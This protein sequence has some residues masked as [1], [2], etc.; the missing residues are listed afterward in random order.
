M[1]QPAMRRAIRG[2][3]RSNEQPVKAGRRRYDP[4]PA[5]TEKPLPEGPMA[6]DLRKVGRYEEVR[7]DVEQEEELAYWSKT[8]GVTRDELRGAVAKVGPTV[9]E[10]RDHLLFRD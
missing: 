3:R 4:Q 8:F 7:I 1:L 6:D 9:K 5:C 10:V 2:R